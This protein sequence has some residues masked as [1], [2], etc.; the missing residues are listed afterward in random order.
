MPQAAVEVDRLVLRYGATVAVNDA[1]FTVA[2]GSVTA[3]LG[4][5]GAGKTSTIETCE[6]YR[7]P[8]AG[9]VRVLGLDPR[10][11][12]KQLRPRVGVMLQ[13]GGV[14]PGARAEESIRHMA[15]LYA[16]PLDPAQ[17]TDRLGLTG[18]RTTYRR[19][20]GGERQRLKFA[21]AI[22]GRP[23]LVFLDEPTAGLDPQAKHTVRRLIEQLRSSGVTVVLT[24]HLMEDAE[25]LADEI[26]V[27]DAGGVVAS[28]TPES[29]MA[30]SKGEVVFQ[31]PLRLDLASLALAL[32]QGCSV[33]EFPPGT[34]RVSGDV[35]PHAL[36]AVTAWCAQRGVMPRQL[37][38]SGRSLEDV[39]LSLTG[40]QVRP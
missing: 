18:L 31:G 17:L 32:P 36:A 10:T 7:C 28:G 29:L 16:N 22:V 4:P 14:A 8:T 40:N 34:Y 9:L 15:S 6:G 3:V 37:T 11:D 35:G 1:S 12:A 5:N 19:M 39:F 26:V 38:T 21:I 24:T 30:E 13:S 27:M 20:S 23:E 33:S 2:R 25:Q